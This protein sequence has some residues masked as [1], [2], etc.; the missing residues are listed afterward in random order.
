MQLKWDDRGLKS[1]LT[2]ARGLGSAH[3]GVHHWVM[4]RVSA[5]VAIFLCIWLVYAGVMMPAWNWSFVTL[6]LAQPLH[7]ILMIGF[8]A[9]VF[10]HTSLGV[11]VVLED[12]V[13][14]EGSKFV[15]IWLNHMLF[16][17]CAL[18]GILSVLKIA[19][20]K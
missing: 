9:T 10:Y 14:G 7:A 2:R 8:I 18:I 20:M 16:A 1:P 3:H 12:Y 15:S 17:A 6:W 11:Q 5:F 19:F 4:E 13:H